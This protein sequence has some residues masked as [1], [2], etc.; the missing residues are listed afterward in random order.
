MNNPEKISV[1]SY[2]DP[3]KLTQVYYDVEMNMK[4]SLLVHLVKQEHAGL[5]MVFCNTQR[6]TDFV[7]KNLQK[8]G[9]NA[10]STHGGL[11]QAKRNLTLNKFKSGDAYILVCTDVAARGLHVEN[12]THVYNYDQPKE[13]KQYIHRVGRTARAGKEGKAINL[14]STSDHENFNR[15]LRDNSEFKIERV[16]APKFEQVYVVMIDRNKGR[17]QKRSFGRNNNHRGRQRQ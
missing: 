12:V 17:G 5:I 14:I 15:V 11:T 4:F 10:V 1:E 7:A 8:Q 2:V 3:S 9:L 6:I 13:S 16:E